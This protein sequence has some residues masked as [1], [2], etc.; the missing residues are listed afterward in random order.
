MVGSATMLTTEPSG[1]EYGP[2]IV[3]VLEAMP[4][5]LCPAPRTEHRTAT[6]W[7][8]HNWHLSPTIPQQS[9]QLD[10]QI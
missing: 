6:L 4:G 2:S 7:Q 1:S 3:V 10:M 8:T 5:T 9:L